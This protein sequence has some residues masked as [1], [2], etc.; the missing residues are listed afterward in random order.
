MDFPGFKPSQL[1]SKKTF[2]PNLFGTSLVL[3]SCRLSIFPRLT[4]SRFRIAE[5]M[6]EEESP[7][8]YHIFL[9]N[10]VRDR[11]TGALETLANRGGVKGIAG[12][13]NVNSQRG[14][15]SSDVARRRD[16]YGT[17][18][19]PAMETVGYLELLMEAFSDFTVLMLVAASVV[20]LVL[21]FAYEKTAGSYAEGF[22]ILISVLIVT[23]VTA[24]ND[25]S[26]QKQFQKLNA[27]VEDYS[28]RALRDGSVNDVRAADLVVG[29]IVQLAVGDIFPTD[30]LLLQG[31]RVTTDESA[32]TG[33]PKLISKD[34]INAPFLLSGTKV[35]EGSGTFL[36]I[37]VGVNSEAGQIRELIRTKRKSGP[38]P[39]PT[40][41]DTAARENSDTESSGKQKSVLTAKL[42]RIAVFVGK[43]ATVIASAALIV[44]CVR[45]AVLTYGT[46]DPEYVCYHVEDELCSSQTVFDLTSDGNGFEPCADP[47]HGTTCCA[48]TSTG[49]DIKG[50]PCPWMRNQLGEFLG[51]LITAI[52]ILVVAVPEG[53]PLAVTLSLAFSVRKMQDENNLVKH[54]DACETMGS[55]T[56]IC[57]DKTGTLTKNRMTVVR[58]LVGANKSLKSND[59][60]N[61]C[62]S[63]IVESVCL[64]GNADIVYNTDI[65]LWDQIGSKTECA[66]LQTVSD[67][68]K[69]EKD[70]YKKIRSSE[71]DR[72]V[73][74]FPFSSA[75]KKSSFV[76]RTSEG[77]RIY[78]IGASEIV[79]GACNGILNLEGS[80]SSNFTAMTQGYRQMVEKTIEDYANEAMRTLCIS[81]KDVS[82]QIN[83]DSISADEVGHTL[84]CLVG[85]EDPLRDEVPLAIQKCN[86]AGVDV[87]MVTGDNLNTA[88]AIAKRCNIIRPSDV[89]QTSGT[90]KLNVAMTGPDFRQRVLNK[91]GNIIQEEL[92][93]IW[94]VLRVLA[95]SSPTDKY[96]LVS[97]MLSSK[98]NLGGDRQVIAVT[99]DGTNDA[100]ALKKA[101]VGF[102]MGITGTAVARDAA[103]I[104]LLD[105]NFAS[106]VVACKWG[107]N[108]FD[109]IQKFLQFQ[110]TV[111]I[112]AVTIAI[113]GAFINNESPIGAVQMLWVNLIMDALA[114]LALATEPPTEALLDR[115]P[116][117]RN[118]SAVSEIMI[119]NIL[120]QGVYQLT[121][122]NL[123]YFLGPDWFGI[124]SGV[125]GGHD[126]PPSEHYT[127]VFNSLVMMQLSNQINSRRLYHEFNVFAGLFSNAY[128]TTILAVEALLQVIFV[129]FGGT[130]V[131]TASLPGEL[132]AY[133]VG[134]CFIAFPVQW[135]IILIRKLVKGPKSESTKT[136]SSAI[137]NEGPSVPAMA[138]GHQATMVSRE[139]ALVST[140]SPLPSSNKSNGSRSAAGDIELGIRVTESDRNIGASLH[141]QGSGNAVRAFST[142]NLKD[143]VTGPDL[144]TLTRTTS[145]GFKNPRRQTATNER[146]K[147]LSSFDQSNE[148]FLQAAK[149]Y[150]HSSSSK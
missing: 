81:Y 109:S 95:R 107:R 105:D 18:A 1:H 3:A 34:P 10:L 104:I 27:T 9:R 32:L 36:V 51:F 70:H 90:P 88:I 56:T 83:L 31:D 2:F 140:I 147:K 120:G 143:L 117:G 61:W 58:S 15:D 84:I 25:Y 6:S 7:S 133:S 55:A 50:S 103:D 74:R 29:D 113:E 121:I 14:V 141:K 24:I 49:A 73:K 26:K 128:F 59:L 126:A 38:K 66:L 89:D 79:L 101:D 135:I 139:S 93:K 118:K 75:A 63:M 142:K 54:L 106:I 42:D 48:D 4:K 96:T 39:S 99:G 125:G 44:M 11:G 137:S 92:D 102:A 97:G 87:K 71:S 47:N 85:I 100:P 136:P 69:F 68:M 67:D 60:P 150:K 131:N 21:A 114:S 57:S 65:R 46:T 76:I 82:S 111:N 123:I 41:T 145:G 40:T 22:A 91:D 112:V 149:E 30:G 78:M 28:V 17:N 5:I 80:V 86:N 13:L 37:A 33:E 110:L 23:N 94:P 119:W 43:L 77:Y 35:M 52:T 8:K 62:K 134:F 72:V 138:T 19:P 64:S 129:Q 124:D 148:D 132:W 115:P 130:W 16:E 12:D 98:L 45:Y 146:F 20:S 108:V 53:L 144:S 116:H 127:M 122:L